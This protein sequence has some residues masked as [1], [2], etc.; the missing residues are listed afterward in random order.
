MDR[1]NQRRERLSNDVSSERRAAT[2][3]PMSLEVRYVILGS[4]APARVGSGRTIDLSISGLCFTADP[5]L[6]TGQRV[7]IFI[8]WP[9]LLGGDVHLQLVACGVVVPPTG[10]RQRCE[11][12]GTSS[13]RAV[14]D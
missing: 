12:S 2:R 5:P 11:S 14:P 9:A 4:G 3:F 7:D 13:R 10:H 1:V 8:D 6:S